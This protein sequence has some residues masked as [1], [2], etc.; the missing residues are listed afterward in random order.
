[1]SSFGLQVDTKIVQV[2]EEKRSKEVACLGKKVEMWD[3]QVANLRDD[4]RWGGNTCP[5]VFEKGIT[6]REL[7]NV[8]LVFGRMLLEVGQKAYRKTQGY[9]QHYGKV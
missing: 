7:G 6:F 3:L 5:K 8:H 1:M 9:T 2:V 4:R